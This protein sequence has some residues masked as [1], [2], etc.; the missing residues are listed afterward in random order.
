MG[1]RIPVCVVGVG[2]MG[3]HHAR[4]YHELDRAQ[5]VA[6]VD[7]NSERARDAAEAYG[8]QAFA[9]VEEL[10]ERGPQVRA[11]T[12]A[13]PTA[14]HRAVAEALLPRGIACL[15]EKPIAPSAAEARAIVELAEGYGTTVQVGH[16]ER[17]N[18]AVRAMAELDVRPRFVEADRVA[19]MSFRSVDVGV[20]FDLMI[21]DIDIA[22]MLA[23]SPVE[24]V[25]AVGVSILGT[26]EDVAN[27]R[28]VF[29]GGCVANLTA[30]RL[31]RKT[32]RKLR[33]FG[34]TAYVSL[35]YA[36]RSGVILSAADNAQALATLRERMLSGEDLSGLDYT[37]VVKAR[38][39]ELTDED[40][41]QAELGHFID[42]VR[43]GT[44][45]AVDASAGYAAVEVA[46][47]VVAAIRAHLAGG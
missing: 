37:E 32:E 45:P 30:S 19:P 9:S 38:E 23:G 15:I 46:E 14:G 13:T 6:V 17:F 28:L 34:E 43:E 8:A 21:H 18:P 31:A 2:R 40:P 44:R 36:K 10:L 11:A 4:T 27:A 16:T 47:R 3:R 5:L 26:H 1:E 24:D 25:S 22:L 42:A 33:V 7:G 35:D 41:L 29:A 39:I 20:V 12:I